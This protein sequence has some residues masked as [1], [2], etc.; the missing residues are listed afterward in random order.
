MNLDPVLVQVLDPVLVLVLDPVLDL[1]SQLEYNSCCCFWSCRLFFQTNIKSLYL[2][3]SPDDADDDDDDGGAYC[4]KKLVGS[5]VTD[6]SE[7][8]PSTVEHSKATPP[9][10]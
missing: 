10:S 7:P 9:A 2:P 5:D 6:K 1:V 3:C 8:L 4:F